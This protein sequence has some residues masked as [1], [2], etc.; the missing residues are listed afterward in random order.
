MSKV[1]GRD[2]WRLRP[3]LI[4]QTD[5]FSSN[6]SPEAD[7]SFKSA[8][9]FDNFFSAFISWRRTSEGKNTLNKFSDCIKQKAAP[10]LEQ[11]VLPRTF[12]QLGSEVSR[13]APLP[14][15]LPADGDGWFD[16][17]RSALTAANFFFANTQRWANRRQ[18]R[19][20]PLRCFAAEWEPRH[21]L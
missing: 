5:L 14:C 8:I 10:C 17:Q 15:R 16:L 1:C 4:Q 3:D 21:K 13:L 11:L 20:S 6:E 18:R 2:W 19:T 12:L 7:D 9:A